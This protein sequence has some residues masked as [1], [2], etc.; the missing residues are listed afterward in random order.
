MRKVTTRD[1]LL[2]VIT[3]DHDFLVK[4]VSIVD[5]LKPPEKSDLSRKRKINN[6]KTIRADKSRKPGVPNQ[7]DPRINPSMPAYPAIPQVPYHGQ[8]FASMIHQRLHRHGAV[9]Q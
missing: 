3:S 2:T 6:P 1:R 9:I 7:T 4:A 8:N 5:R